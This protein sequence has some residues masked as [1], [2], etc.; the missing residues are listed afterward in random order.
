MLLI[1]S[2]TALHAS[3]PVQILIVHKPHT[4]FPSSSSHR[5][6]ELICSYKAVGQV[7]TKGEGE[8]MTSRIIKMNFY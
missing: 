8:G 6:A 7:N 4:K 1:K 3:S 5:V 2:H